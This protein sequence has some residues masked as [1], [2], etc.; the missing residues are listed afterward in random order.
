[1]MTW[2]FLNLFHRV[3][4]AADKAGY[5]NMRHAAASIRKD[6]MASI[7]KAPVA[8]PEVR[9][10][11]VKRNAQ[12]RFVKGSGKSYLARARTIPAPP[13]SPPHTRRGQ[14]R[15]AIV[16]AAT[17]DS[18]VIGPRYSVIELAAEAHEFGE[19]H[20]KTNYPAR[21]TMGPA[22]ARNLARFAS[23]WQGSI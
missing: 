9:R 22:L 21:P 18:A 8:P 3:E 1:M 10:R 6:A 12:G 19:P 2:L 5:K 16:Y 7:K 14:L 4:Q 11:K 23:D 17:D 15:R 20:K 13:G